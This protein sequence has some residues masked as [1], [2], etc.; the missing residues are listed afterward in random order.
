MSEPRLLIDND[1]FLIIAGAGLLDD[2]VA[3]LGFTMPNTLRR[4]PLPYMIA[5]SKGIQK[6]F[7]ESFRANALS[8]T[9]HVNE[10][11]VR[12]PG[13]MHELLVG[14]SD[15]D[16]GEAELYAHLAAGNE[17]FLASGDKRAMR[18][19]CRDAMLRP[20]REAIAGRVICLET[21]LKLLVHIRGVTSIAA[22]F[23]PMRNYDHKTI[24]IVFSD[25]N[26]KDQNAS[27]QAL[28]SAINALKVDLGPDFLLER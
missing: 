16:E 18:S 20:V 11:T 10:I 6:A 4:Q 15:V 17:Y 28:D 13:L 25:A 24:R 5:R 23:A 21:M 7:P 2:C 27:I 12:P 8:A 19:I 9:Q 14:A 3:A 26:I 1:A 22:C